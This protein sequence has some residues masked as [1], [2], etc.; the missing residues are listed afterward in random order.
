VPEPLGGVVAVFAAAE[1]VVAG[2][3]ELL[4]V[5]LLELPHAAKLTASSREP[6][7]TPNLFLITTS[8][9]W[10]FST[11]S[12]RRGFR[13]YASSAGPLRLRVVTRTRGDQT[14]IYSPATVFLATRALD[15][16]IS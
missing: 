14:A 10:S 4:L 6:A 12:R 9:D 3:E 2:A 8:P 7:S 15:V 13:P 5:V 16:N 1:L 11:G